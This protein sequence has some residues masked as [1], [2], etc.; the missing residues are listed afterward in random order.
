M[1]YDIN[2]E[3]IEKV[4]CNLSIM[5]NMEYIKATSSYDSSEQYPKETQVTNY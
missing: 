3:S 5:K 1:R 4:L 2:I